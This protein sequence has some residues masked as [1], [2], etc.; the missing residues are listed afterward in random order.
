MYAQAC[1]H[2]LLFETD[3]A[4]LGFSPDTRCPL[5]RRTKKFKKKKKKW[6]THQNKEK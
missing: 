4:H 5:C 1:H 3:N 6:T 2:L